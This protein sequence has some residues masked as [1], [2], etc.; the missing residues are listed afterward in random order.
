M[1]LA[2]LMLQPIPESVLKQLNQ[3]TELCQNSN[4]RVEVDEVAKVL[5]RDKRSLLNSM[6]YNHCPF[7]FVSSDNAR[8][9]T[10]PVAKFYM[11]FMCDVINS[12]VTHDA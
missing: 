9:A 8:H 2:D 10:I 11:W 12:A 4:G 3:V 1:T 5:N 6:Q 7:G